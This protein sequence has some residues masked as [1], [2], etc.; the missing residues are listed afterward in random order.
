MV[1][2]CKWCPTVNAG[3][4]Y[5]FTWWPLVNCY[6]SKIVAHYL[7]LY[8]YLHQYIANGHGVA[9]RRGISLLCLLYLHFICIGICI[10]IFVFLSVCSGGVV[11]ANGPGVAARRGNLMKCPSVTSV[12]RSGWRGLCIWMCICVCFFIRICISTCICICICIVYCQGVVA[13]GHGVAA[14]RGDL[15]K[16]TSPVSRSGWWGLW[17]W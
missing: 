15:M 10:S 11:V 9:A 5:Q 7:Y 8:F 14:R 12:S 13:N 16:C 1:S 2:F 3:L 6:P 17:W 4:L